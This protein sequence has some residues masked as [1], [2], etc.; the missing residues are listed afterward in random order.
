MQS[1]VWHTRKTHTNTPANIYIIGSFVYEHI[2]IT[3]I[4]DDD[5]GV[6]DAENDVL[7]LA[8]IIGNHFSARTHDDYDGRLFAGHE[9]FICSHLKLKAIFVCTTNTSPSRNFL[10]FVRARF[11]ILVCNI[12]NAYDAAR[13]NMPNTCT[14]VHMNM[15]AVFHM[16]GQHS[17]TKYNNKNNNNRPSTTT[18]RNTNRRL[19]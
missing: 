9:I 16:R 1:R 17:A 6:D 2:H 10:V 14:F 5:D 18:T 12:L 8:K 11:Y 4:D 7:F 19:T 15:N 3:S 13:A